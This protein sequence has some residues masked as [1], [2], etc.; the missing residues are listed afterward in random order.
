MQQFDKIVRK[1]LVVAVAFGA[2]LAMPL[3]FAQSSNANAHAQHDPAAQSAAPATPATP[4]T[5]A[6][7]SD[8]ATQSAQSATPATPATPASPATAV[9]K[10]RTWSELDTDKNG[11]LSQG[12]AS[13]IESLGKAFAQADA[14]ADGQLTADEYKAFVAAN[15]KA[16]TETG[17]SDS[18]S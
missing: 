13:A 15:G 3:A 9:A 14:N 1:P 2:A 4:A 5:P 7:E 17:T 10:K 18:G 11:T 8:T 12:E 6:S 16:G